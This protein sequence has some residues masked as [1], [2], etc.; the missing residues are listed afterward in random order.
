MKS[1]EDLIS[2]LTKDSDMR[3]A[4]QVVVGQ[5]LD[6]LDTL[7]I[8]TYDQV[9]HVVHEGSEFL[10]A[11]LESS[12]HILE[13]PNSI[14]DDPMSTIFNPS[15]TASQTPLT[16]QIELSFRKTIE[17]KRVLSNV[18]SFLQ[19]HGVIPTLIDK[20]TLVC[21]ELFTNA[22]FNAPVG[23]KNITLSR[24]TKIELGEEFTSTLTVAIHKN[25][26]AVTCHDKFGSLDTNSYLAKI[27]SCYEKGV[28]SAMNMQIEGGAGIGSFLM[29]GLCSSMYIAVRKK[30]ETLVG[31][32][33]STD[34]K[35]NQSPYKTKSIHLLSSED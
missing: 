14:F 20:I 32:V 23:K 34:R 21:D 4:R 15:G 35:A 10:G 3:Q 16:G 5:Q 8:A 11:D 7:K 24:L 12:M 29:Y 27:I 13:V 6:E 9:D 33:F 26:V 30:K 17:K 22:I 25:R 18:I 2:Y 31:F 28:R 1:R 19:N